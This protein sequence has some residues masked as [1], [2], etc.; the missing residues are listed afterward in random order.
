M[1]VHYADLKPQVNSY[2]QQ[3][4]Q[5]KWDVAVHGRDIYFVKP[6]LGPPKKFQHLT[7]AEEVIIT[8]WSLNYITQPFGFF[9]WITF[10]LILQVSLCPPPE[11][12][13]SHT[14]NW[15]HSSLMQPKYIA[16][17]SCKMIVRD[18]PQLTPGFHRYVCSHLPLQHEICLVANSDNR[19]LLMTKYIFQ[20]VMEH[21]KCFDQGNHKMVGK[22]SENFMRT[23]FQDNLKLLRGVW[24]CCPL[25]IWAS[26]NPV[27]GLSVQRQSI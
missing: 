20:I 10:K 5:I 7:R 22:N 8:R 6:T 4:V 15:T 9:A 23:S 21:Q 12:D 14:Q 16:R 19:F 11:W 2:I 1:G 3:L 13:Q 26:A 17:Y 24:F 25:R 18:H 27:S